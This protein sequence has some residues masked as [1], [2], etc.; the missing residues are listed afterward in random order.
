MR[1]VVKE[2]V[3]TKKIAQFLNGVKTEMSKVSWPPREELIGSTFIVVILSGLL[4]VFIF[5]IDTVL[6]N[7]MRL[8]FG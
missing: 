3:M 8:F 1:A 5:C 6:S 4:A 2:A 7:I